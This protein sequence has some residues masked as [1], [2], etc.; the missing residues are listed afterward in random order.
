MSC[1]KVIEDDAFFGGRYKGKV[2]TVHSNLTGEEK[3]ET[4]QQLLSVEEPGQSHRDRDPRQHAERR[5][6]RDEP[7]HNCSAAGGELEDIGGAINRKGTAAAVRQEE[8][9]SWR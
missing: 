7:L 1:M 5:L 3:D 4:V 8:S 6:G 2:I 9:A